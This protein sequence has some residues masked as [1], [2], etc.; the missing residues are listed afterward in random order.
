MENLKNKIL[1]IN[2]DTADLAHL[3]DLIR[4]R[5]PGLELLTART[6]GQGL[7]LAVSE[8]PDVTLLDVHLPDMDAFEVCRQLK[9]APETR[10]TPVIFLAPKRTER[11]VR[12][13]SLEAGAETFLATPVNETKLVTNVRAMQMMKNATLHLRDEKEQLAQ[14]LAGRTREMEETHLATLNLLEDLHA[15]NEARK[16]S[17]AALQQAQRVAHVG[18]WVWHIQSNRLEWSDE[19]YHIFGLQKEHFTGD[20]NEVIAHAIHPDDRHKVEQ[21]NMTVI[22]ER[23]PV[24]LEY[25]I[26]W[27][28]GTVRVVWAEAGELTLDKDGNSETITGIVQDITERKQAEAALRASEQRYRSIVENSPVGIFQSTPQGGYLQINP[29][30]AHM[31]G[32]ASSEEALAGITDIAHQVYVNP[33]ER[34]IFKRTLDRKGQI[35]HFINQNYRKDGSIIWTSTD[36]RAVKDEQGKV[37]YYEGFMIDITES[38]QTQS[39]QEAGYQI[40][41]AAETTTSLDEL[42]PHIHQIISSVMPAHNFYIA[43]YDEVRNILRFPYFQDVADVPFMQEV[44]PGHGVTAYVLRTGK[45]LLYT[46]EVQAD[47]ERRGE[48]ELQGVS[49][50]I[51]LGVPLNVEGK[52][53]GVMAVQHYT[54][55]KAYGERELHMLEFVSSQVALTINRKRAEAA[56]RESETRYRGLFENSPVA[57]WE[58]DF[59]VVKHHIDKLKQQGV[60]YFRAYFESHPDVLLECANEIKVLDVN[61]ATLAMMRAT[62]KSQL[63]GNLQKII[64]IDTSMGFVEEFV[65]IAE[66]KTEFSWEGVN[67]TLDGEKLN[68]SLQWSAAPG[69]ENTLEKVL[70][71]LVDITGSKQTQMLQEAVYQIAAAAERTTSLDELYP[72]IHQIISSVMPAENFFI[73]LYDEAENLLRF[74]Y[75]KDVEDEAFLGGIH[76]GKGL[77]A[78]VLR[79]GRSLLCTQA[80]HDELER[81]GEIKLL[82]VPSAIWLGVPLILEGKTIGAMVVQHYSEP[83]AYGEREQ[84]MLEFVSTQVAIAIN[85]KQAEENLRAS[86]D[87]FSKLFH[88]SPDAVLLS[89]LDS[90]KIV[91]VNKTF[92]EYSGYSHD[93]LVGHSVMDFN[94]YSPESRQRFVSMV[95]DHSS[96]RN[97]EFT[98]RNKSGKVMAVLAS[99]DMV[100]I[101]NETHTLTILRDITERKRAEE[102]I[103]LL[104]ASLEQRVRERTRQLQSAQEQLVRNEKLAVLGQLAGGVGHELRNPLGV[105]NSAVYYLK[106]VQPDVDEKI[107]HYHLMIEQ[108]VQ[109]AGQI[110]NDLLDFGRI[111]SP[112]RQPVALPGLIEHVLARF[113]V[114]DS[115]QVVVKL[116][117]SLP[118][119]YAD[120]VQVEQVLGNL[121]TN[122]CQAMKTGGKLTFSA[123][124]KKD[125]VAIL[126]KDTGTGITPENMEKLFEPLFTTKLRGIG[127]GLAVS[128]KLAEANAGRIE[129]Q[130]EPGKGSTFTLYLPVKESS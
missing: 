35:S 122:A 4:R 105:I 123:H 10:S 91:E 5:L 103:R 65:S 118:R 14:Q 71:S 26:V 97:E 127:L 27:P 78:Y 46:A 25:R 72:Q 113:P 63:I 124:L 29:H 110:I 45:P 109:I 24:P 106:L 58:E 67:Y 76:P 33:A 13:Q 9:S 34:Q 42:Y 6:G 96:I 30:L 23:H 89:D 59:S 84:H 11:K 54:D 53:I 85:R 7:A 61:Q 94:M 120:P 18:S 3:A 108:E 100:E 119:L 55:P 62:S 90:G 12:L 50:A 115:V 36:A 92:E 73:T 99:A 60:T 83:K 116:P 117:L 21:A 112:D 64:H 126:V 93:E 17:E 38:R 125:L 70:V 2:D 129:V 121:T 68:I 75:F 114:P 57:L 19:M 102:E 77:S 87:K 111:V 15:E 31:Y 28:D 81:K 52:T 48:V 130:S 95:R 56:L 40:A 128:K 8:D 49:S 37:L 82:G 74:P 41:A 88:S 39:L 86:E 47:L 79:T 101:N 98:L 20:L 16:Q 107:K 44:P 1:L 22:Q 66:G 69:F 32:Y 43:L 104:N 80:V 51:W